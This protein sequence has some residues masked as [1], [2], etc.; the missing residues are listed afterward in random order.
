VQVSSLG[1]I[2]GDE[3]VWGPMARHL[4]QGE[5]TT[6]YWG[7][8]YG[9]TQEVFLTA[10]LFASFGTSMIAARIV[11]MALVAIASVL[12]WRIGK[13]TIGQQPAVV[14]GALLWIWPPY[15]V[16]KSDRAHGF[17]GSGLVLATLVL[18]LVLRLVERPSRKTALCSAS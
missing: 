3:A 7:Q 6:F 14:A 16:W 18:L 17:Y 10:P 11:P 9:G 2:D 15:L 1:V 8:G 4:L 13:R 12:V 5:V